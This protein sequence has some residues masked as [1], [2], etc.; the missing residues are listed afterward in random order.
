MSYLVTDGAA[1]DEPMGILSGDFV[2]VGDVGRPDL[3]ETAAGQIGAMEGSA[4]VLYKSL[5]KFKSL[6]EYLQLWPGHGAGSACGKALGAVPKS[7]VGYEQKFNKSIATTI[8]EKSFV[9]FILDGQPEPPLYFARMKRDNKLGPK[10]L[11][12][13]PKPERI[14]VNEIVEATKSD[15]AVVIDT[16]NRTE[17]MSGHLKGSILAIMNKTFN[18]IAGSYVTEDQDIYL[19]ID[20]SKVDEAVVDLI[21]IGLDNIKGFAT[22][23]DLMDGKVEMVSTETINF[24]QVDELLQKGGYTL[25]DVRKKSEYDEGHGEGALNIAHTRLLERVEEVPSNQPV[26]VHCKSGARA[27]AAS[28]LLENKGHTV[29][30]VDDKVEPWLE[31]TNRLVQA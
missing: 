30:Y 21:R 9:D 11:G 5:E 12:E 10:V 8:N 26:I 23:A 3:L 16:R 19:I 25:L 6:P 27:S 15:N 2:F 7:T 4:K 1:T 18:T 29:F 28:S 20:E 31:R 13:L 22:P 14:A 17:F 24:D